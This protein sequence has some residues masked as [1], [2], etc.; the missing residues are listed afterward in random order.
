MFWRKNTH[1]GTLLLTFHWGS[2]EAVIAS[3]FDSYYWH[4]KERILW[5]IYWEWDDDRKVVCSMSQFQKDLLWNSAVAEVFLSLCRLCLPNIL[6][7]GVCSKG[8][9]RTAWTEDSAGGESRLITFCFSFI[10]SLFFLF[11]SRMGCIWCS[12][13]RFGSM[14]SPFVW[15]I[16][17]LHCTNKTKIP[18][19][20]PNGF[21]A[22]N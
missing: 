9:E 19:T 6:R 13:L 14:K 5:L 10:F 7:K 3:L 18:P 20:H 4:T 2:E 8:P 17:Y 1:S 21:Q 22:Q 11:K 16:H 15:M 12:H